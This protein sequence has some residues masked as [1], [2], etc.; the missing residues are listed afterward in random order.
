MRVLVVG[1]G[2]GGLAAA[3]ALID[4]GHDV[5]VV[6]RAES[7]RE[8]GAA[9]ILWSG[10]TAVLHDIGISLDGLGTRLEV[11]ENRGWDGRRLGRIRVGA[12]TRRFGSPQVCVRR[13]DVVRRLA[14]RLPDGV[15]EY[16]KKAVAVTQ[17]GGGARVRLED[18]TSRTGDVVVGADG[19]RSVVRGDLHGPAEPRATGWVT[20]Q[21]MLTARADADITGTGLFVV[22][23]EG[24]VGMFDA[25]NHQVQWW[26]DHPWRPDEPRP[27][28]VVADLADRFGHWADPV[29]GLL[30]RVDDATIGFYP[31]YGHDV[32]REWGRGRVTLLGDAAHLMPPTAGQGANQALEDAWVLARA[33]DHAPDVPAALRDYERRRARRARLASRV[34]MRERANQYRPRQARMLPDPVA[35]ALFVRWLGLL[36]DRLAAGPV[37]GAAGA[38]PA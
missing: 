1:A 3:V 19:G 23:P 24:L 28:S 32:A 17:D 18:G 16:G 15:V 11:L 10:G 4:R 29:P 26:F 21:G 20:W 13:R 35:T 25:G 22:G 37:D 30:A 36:S 34:A 7:P 5:E 31:H 6:E 8:T 2:I 12:A 9:F 33:L 27:R 38:A 14:A